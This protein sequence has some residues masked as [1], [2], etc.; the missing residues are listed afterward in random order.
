MDQPTCPL[1]GGS[2]RMKRPKLL[3]HVP[4]CRKC[5]YG[6]ANWRQLAYVL[7]WILFQIV[8]L[9]VGYGIGY[10]MATGGSSPSQIDTTMFVMSWLVLP[11]VFFM[12]DGF[13]G[14]S[15]GK[16]VTGVRVLDRDTL[17]PAGF[18]ASWK[19]N[20]ILLVP[21]MP[22]F[23]AFFLQKGQRIGDGWANTKVIWKRYATHPLFTGEAVCGHCQYDL[24]GNTTGTCPECGTPV[25]RRPASP[26]TTPP[27]Q[28]A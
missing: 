14:Y 6:F 18:F 8:A 3:Y 1:C 5:Y 15:P 25:A 24:K 21:F 26:E 12:K 27:V 16:F 22:L 19:R 9:I 13:M 20:L 17:E 10:A 23:V 28:P 7:D 4:V 11:M 2:K